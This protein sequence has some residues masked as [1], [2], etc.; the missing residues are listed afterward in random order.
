MNASAPQL[1]TAGEP[2]LPFPIGLVLFSLLALSL[3][4]AVTLTPVARVAYAAE[5]PALAR[6]A[7]SGLWVA[8]AAV[9]VVAVLKGGALAAV[10]WA[11]LVLTGGD[12][13]YRRAFGVVL[14]GELV[15]AA[16]ALWIALLLHLRGLS[17]IESPADLAVV[18]GLD[19]LFPDPTTPLGA[20]AVTVTPFHAAWVLFLA[21]GFRRAGGG[22]VVAA[23]GAALACWGPGAAV[24]ILRA[25]GG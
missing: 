3:L 5:A 6:T 16:Q 21:W 7:L 18:T 19:Y 4:T 1:R 17:A 10:A 2:P 15:L 24:G 25:M 14:A 11:V 22:G 13:P 8:S 9:P 12:I 23:A 20:L